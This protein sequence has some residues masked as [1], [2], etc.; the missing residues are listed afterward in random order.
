MSYSRTTIREV[1]EAFK[2][3]MEERTGKSS[4]N[5]I[6]PPELIYYFLRTYANK[7][8][9][10][11]RYIKAMGRTYSDTELVLPCVDLVKTDMVECPCAPA[12]GCKF[13]KSKYPL[14]DM[15]NGLP[16]TV[17]LIKTD[18]S[19][20]NYGIF[21]FVEWENF[22]FKINSRIKAQAT[23]PYYTIKKFDF[24]PYLYVYANVE[25]YGN[26]K[27][28][29]V[30]ADFTDVIEVANFPI[31]GKKVKKECNPLDLEF[32]IGKELESKVFEET[33]QALYNYKNF[34]IGQDLLN[35]DRNNTFDK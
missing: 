28:V 21:T 26:L 24:K 31:C 23:Q 2:H 17:S 14:P 20:K 3:F 25:E 16:K 29:T 19:Q 11:D 1:V 15:I 22:E 18:G 13:F 9:Y 7:I 12:S 35:D 4:S 30:A 10:Q 5:F 27:A 8:N 32:V 34:T 33:F 6:Y